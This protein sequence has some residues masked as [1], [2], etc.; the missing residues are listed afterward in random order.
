[1]EHSVR[2]LLHLPLEIVTALFFAASIA[3][4]A[5]VVAISYTHRLGPG[6]TMALVAFLLAAAGFGYG[7]WRTY[8][9]R[10]KRMFGRLPTA[11]AVA[12]R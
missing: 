11:S 1:M 9:P 3:V 10:P 5:G 7:L 6:F 2:T 8:R 12:P 4:G